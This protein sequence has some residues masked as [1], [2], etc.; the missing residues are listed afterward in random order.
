VYINVIFKL[1][2]LH[3]ITRLDLTEDG[4]VKAAGSSFD[5]AFP[6]ELADALRRLY[7]LRRGPLLSPGPL[8]SNDDRAQNRALFIRL[9]LE[10]CLCMMAPS[11][12]SSGILGENSTACC[13]L[14]SVPP[15]T[16]TLWEKVSGYFLSCLPCTAMVCLQIF[17]LILCLQSV[18]A[19]DHYHNVFIWSGRLA[20]ASQFDQAR[21][22]ARD[23]LLQRCKNRFPM[24]V[25]HELIEGES[26]GRRFLS[27]LSPSHGDPL[28]HQ[29]A[30]FPRLAQ[31]SSDELA[32]I[33]SK[34]R[35]YDASTDPSF[36]DWFWSVAGAT[37]ISKEYGLSLCE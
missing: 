22:V 37:S 9:P 13:T 7:H 6:P 30:N 1:S 24:A 14:E 3:W 36:R 32:A 21:S 18:V 17:I 25:L 2:N 16:L 33:R 15:D 26:M 20:K 12:W 5:F 27:L 11:L 23:F 4:G 19:A 29:L 31:L 35:F 10:D 34:Y 28:D 8:K